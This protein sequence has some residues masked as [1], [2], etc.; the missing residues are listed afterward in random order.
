[1]RDCIAAARLARGVVKGVKKRLRAMVEM[2]EH[3]DSCQSNQNQ[4]EQLAYELV[5]DYLTCEVST[6]FQPI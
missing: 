1:M 4:Q 6:S 5:S 2:E 3:K